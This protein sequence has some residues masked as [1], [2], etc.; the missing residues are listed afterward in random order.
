MYL[1][2]MPK[3]VELRDIKGTLTNS[4]KNREYLGQKEKKKT[5]KH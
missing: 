1:R 5:I 4:K 2:T 3:W